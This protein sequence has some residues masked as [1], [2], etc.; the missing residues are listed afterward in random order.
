MFAKFKCAA[1]DAEIEKVQITQER[2]SW[3]SRVIPNLGFLFFIAYMGY[4]ILGKDD[5]SKDLQLRDVQKQIVGSSLEVVGVV[6]N[7]SKKRWERP[8]IEAE[9]YSE[10]GNFLGEISAKISGT[11][12]PRSQ[13]H[14]SVTEQLI[15]E[16]F[17]PPNG[18][19]K[20]KITG[21]DTND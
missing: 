9:F 15:P 1:C 19:I 10:A 11:I 21:A 8:T 18:Q 13:E 5:F 2:E 4:I 16:K 12:P 14:F 17:I 7:T 6:Q 3:I 20:F